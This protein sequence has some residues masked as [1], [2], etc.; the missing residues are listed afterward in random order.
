[1]LGLQFAPGA[2]PVQPGRLVKAAHLHRVL[3]GRAGAFQSGVFRC[4]EDAHHLQVNVGC[5][6]LVQAQLVL[7]AQLAQRQ[8]AEVQE[9]QLQRLFDL[10]SKVPR[11]QHPADMGLH[12]V[13]LLHRTR[14]A[15][16]VQQGGDEWG[17]VCGQGVGRVHE[18]MMP[19]M[20]SR[21]FDASLL[22]PAFYA[23]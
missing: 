4:V 22:T 1:M 17:K 3:D 19:A 16:G 10:V 20:R 15:P 6:A 23:S 21:A 7:A 18:G 5:K 14:V 12:Q 11:Q 9:R 2:D 8:R 13:H